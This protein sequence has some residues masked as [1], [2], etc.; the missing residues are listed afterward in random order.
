MNFRS[1]K[2]ALLLGAISGAFYC[3]A[4]QPVEQIY[5]KYDYYRLVEQ[6]KGFP[7]NVAEMIIVTPVQK[8]LFWMLLFVLA[9][10]TVH[11]FWKNKIKSEV[12]LW[13]TVAIVAL[14]GL[15]IW[16]Y[17]T[18]KIGYLYRAILSKFERGEWGYIP[19]FGLD[20]ETIEY[21]VLFL[22]LAIAVNFFFGVVVAGL[23][24]R[25]GKQ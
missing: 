17:L 13:Q 4:R 2:L 3:A 7:P 16:S 21:I 8:Y 5:E 11:R 6:F 19:S 18:S 14:G 22:G 9:S 15:S 1:T 20:S 23:T 25:F 24:K 10:Y 12:V